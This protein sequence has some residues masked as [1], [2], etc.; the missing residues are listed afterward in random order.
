[1]ERELEV[2]RKVAREAGKRILEFYRGD[3]QI[4]WKGVDDP[5][6]VADQTAND[7]IVSELRRSFP[8][9]GILA[10]ETPDDSA[11][12]S[13]NRVWM[14]D[15]IDGTKQFIEKVGEFSV[16]IG[17][18]VDGEPQLGVVYQ[19]TIDR[20]LFGAPGIGAFVEEQWSTKRLR[21]PPEDDLSKMK[22]ALSRSH[23]S[24]LVDRI[25]DQLGVKGKIRS[26]SV[27]LKFGLIA[28]GSAHL[29][30]HLSPR[31]NQWD[32]C[33]PEAILRAAGGVITDLNGELLRY[34]KPEIRN[35]TG[36]IA[37]NGTRHAEILEATARVIAE[38]RRC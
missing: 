17:L 10:E 31:T 19:P 4:S 23:H 8:L 6:T 37:S 3:Q 5:V 12:L 29:Y 26:G 35:L 14:I 16:M 34:N 27:G 32:T 18:A 25:C 7:L 36:V 20:L 21:V 13:R 2:A 24:P 15:P 9:D 38:Q 11:R 30:V 28:D 22:I 1:M 33:G